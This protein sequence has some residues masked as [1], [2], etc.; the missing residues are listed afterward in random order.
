MRDWSPMRDILHF[1]KRMISDDNG[2]P[3][4]S[5]V[6]GIV[7]FTILGV[8]V[9]SITG[10]ALWKLYFSTDPLMVRVILDAL[11]KFAWIYLILAAT[12]LSLYG[13]NVWKYIAQIK[14]GVATPFSNSNNDD[15]Y[16]MPRT[17]SKTLNPSPTPSNAIP[18]QT[19]KKVE[20]PHPIPPRVKPPTPGIGSDD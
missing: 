9:G 3:S 8:S 11:N 16:L 20:A 12:A 17:G 14:T 5:R 13:I 19:G 15:D 1:L 2:V 7:I 10:V 6:I 18:I 4:S